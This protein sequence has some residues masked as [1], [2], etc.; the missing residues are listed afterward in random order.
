MGDGMDDGACRLIEGDCLEIL[1]T[2]PDSS[3]DLII[4]DGPYHRVKGEAWDRQWKTDADYLAWIGQLCGEW[5]RVLRPNGSLYVFA[6]PR[7]AARVE[8]VID[9]AF[10]VLNSITWQKDA[11]WSKRQCK[12]EMRAFWP[13]S[14]RIIFAEQF[15]ADNRAKGEAGWVAKC[16]EV[17]GFVF[18]PILSYLVAEFAASRLSRKEVDGH[19]GTANVSQYWLQ[20]RGFIIPTA[21]KWAGLQVLRPRHFRREYEDLRRDYEDLRRDYEDLRRPFSVSAA[22]PYTDVWDFPTVPARPGKHPCEKPLDLAT[23][24]VEASS[25]PDAIVLDCFA[26]S[27][28][29]GEAC[30]RLGRRAIL[31][32]QDPRWVRRAAQRIAGAAPGDACPDRRGSKA[33]APAAPS[34]L[35]LFARSP[36]GAR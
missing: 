36:A 29:V 12:D 1:P 6:S 18:E 9:E 20:A 8:C 13:A 2:L 16:D 21:E 19:F 4:A 31:I 27:G 11:G 5:R 22:V 17:R 32:E 24:I 14:E 35:P 23:H 3:V 33:H 30:V 7:M 26:G 34:F 25:R 10:A 15:G 28:V